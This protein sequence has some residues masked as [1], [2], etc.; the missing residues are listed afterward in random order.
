MKAN[1]MHTF[2]LLLLILSAFDNAAFILPSVSPQTYVPKA[3]FQVSTPSTEKLISFCV[4]DNGKV[5]R[6]I[7]ECKAARDVQRVLNGTNISNLPP[8]V[9]ATAMRVMVKFDRDSIIT[10]RL[11]PDLLNRANTSVLERR[12]TTATSSNK[13]LYFVE[14]VLYSL[15]LLNKHEAMIPTTPLANIC[16][17]ILTEDVN[18]TLKLLHPRRLVE[19][20]ESIN[21]LSLNQPRLLDAVCE[22]LA[23]SDSLGKLQPPKICEGLMA[24]SS[25]PVTTKAFLRR[26]RKQSVRSKVSP[27]HLV[28][29]IQSSGQLAH[30]EDVK[31]I[32]YNMITRELLRPINGD[33]GENLI[34]SLSVKQIVIILRT[35]NKFDFKNIRVVKELETAFERKLGET[36]ER[37]ISMFLLFLR[38]YD[39]IVTQ[40]TGAA[41]GERLLC[42][43][44][45]GGTLE[46]TSFVTALRSAIKL[47]GKTNPAVLRP[48]LETMEYLC[49]HKTGFLSRIDSFQLS[50]LVE[51]LVFV[52]YTEENILLEIAT[53]IVKPQITGSIS[54]SASYRILNSFN[55]LVTRTPSQTL[56]GFEEKLF[57]LL[58]SNLLS[59]KIKPY[60]AAGAMFAYAKAGYILELGIFDHLSEVVSQNAW[61][62]PPRS[63]AQCLWSCGKMYEL[64]TNMQKLP[65]AEAPPYLL[66]AAQLVK[67]LS[68]RCSELTAKDLA[69]CL[70]AMGRLDL[71]D[72]YAAETLAQ[73]ATKLLSTC[74]ACEI[75]NI[76]WG[77]SNIGFDQKEPIITIS[78]RM[79]DSDVSASPKE[80]A[81]VLYALATMG[82]TEDE[83]FSNLTSSMI[84]QM[85]QVSA[86]ALANTLYAYKTANKRPPR[87]LLDAWVTERLGIIGIQSTR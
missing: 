4:N 29:A 81:C 87:T 50:L 9:A 47:F 64:E 26:L 41:L 54:P 24:I 83:I 39:E 42:L 67:N 27:R 17:E 12:N 43:C 75:A 20:A 82:V 45:D 16:C 57:R 69:Q 40:E 38:E 28:M 14:D 52:R 15:S 49:A 86:Q 46:P 31:T 58:G 61:H 35:I 21:S 51:S 80:A 63:I 74:F 73:Q 72:Q 2:L 79:L 56:Q 44:S 85:D 76:L 7:K 23:R 19:V 5:I 84:G 48:Y 37:E 22:R 18:T 6:L 68:T 8:S 34:N 77:L 65:S 66:S 30:D 53:A 78:R 13:T 32:G 33:S 70:W 60:E 36:S 55:I 59:A 3:L 1:L 11:L 10:K 71:Y 25:Y 62:L